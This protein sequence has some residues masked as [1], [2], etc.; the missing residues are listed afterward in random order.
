M[1]KL[2]FYRKFIKAFL[3]DYA[4]KMKSDRKI[5]PQL[6][7]DTER[8]RYLLIRTGWNKDCRIHN[9]VFHFNIQD[10]KIWL[11]ENNTDVDID[12]ELE[13]MGISKQEIVVAFHHPSMRQ[14]SDYAAC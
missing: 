12:E 9:C 6:I 10:G 7:F 1:V 8:D 2:V 14:Y 5:D 3:T 13:D 4:E 11:E